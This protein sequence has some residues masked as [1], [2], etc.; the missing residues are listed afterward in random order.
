MQSSPRKVRDPRLE[1]LE[2]KAE[3]HKPPPVERRWFRDL[4]GLFRPKTSQPTRVDSEL[5][6]LLAFPSETAP[7]TEPTS[8]GGAPKLVRAVAIAGAIIV[9]A[10]LGALA[11]QRLGTLQ[12]TRPG[13]LTIATRPSDAEVLI[14]GERRGTTPLTLSLAPGA[15]TITIRNGSDERVVPLTIASGAE[16]SQYF[17]MKAVEP[18]AVAGRVSIVTD[19]PGARVTVDGKARGISPLTVA[20]L[21]PAEYKITVASDTG[22]AERTVTVAAGGTASVMFSLPKESGPLGGWLS[23][24]APFDVEIAERGEVIGS[25]SA[26]R[27]ML[28]AGRHDITLV[29]RSLGY[30]DARRVDVTAGGTTAIRV[31]PP[32]VAISVNARP[33]AEVAVD[34]A[35]L[36]QTPLANLLV[37]VGSHEIVFRHPQ[38]ADRRQTIVVT[39]NG[40]N[41]FTADLTR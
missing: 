2:K 8:I 34:G 31:D 13:N 28:A 1:A 23:I 18:T 29:N 9:L 16:V 41:R 4:M 24:S 11:M 30:K 20:D 3:L 37:A 15:H 19:P 10:G 33:W 39:A 5:N 14:N 12:P 27:I 26:S 40:P 22:S 21:T 6:A 36:G 25:S 7:R 38:F 32:K 17:E 35:S